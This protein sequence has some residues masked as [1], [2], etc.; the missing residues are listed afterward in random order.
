MME[1][2][3]LGTK[4]SSLSCEVEAGV[5]GLFWC[6]PLQTSAERGL[7]VLHM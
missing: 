5:R 1:F 2:L 4:T 7:L 6:P 3:S